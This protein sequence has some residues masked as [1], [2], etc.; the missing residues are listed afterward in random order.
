MLSNIL[1][2]HKTASSWSLRHK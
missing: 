2:V 1:I